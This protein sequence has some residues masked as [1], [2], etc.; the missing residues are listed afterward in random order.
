MVNT[1]LAKLGYEYINIGMSRNFLP[2]SFLPPSCLQLACC[3][4]E[5]KGTWKFVLVQMIVGR[6]TTGTPRCVLYSYGI[7]HVDMNRFFLKKRKFKFLWS[8]RL[9]S[10]MDR[11]FDQENLTSFFL[12][13][14]NL[15][16]NPSTFPSGMKA[17]SDYVHGKG[18]KLGIYSDAGYAQLTKQKPQSHREKHSG[19]CG[20]QKNILQNACFFNAVDLCL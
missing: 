12:L 19:K 6:P 5:T 18:L 20:R 17:L 4:V 1:G 8:A 15:V 11:M 7:I 2:C 3:S 14:G 13:Q 16:P 9:I 10:V